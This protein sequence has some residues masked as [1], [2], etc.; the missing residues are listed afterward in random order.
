MLVTLTLP[1]VHGHAMLYY[2]QLRK[3]KTT[4]T[5]KKKRK[6][7]LST[8]GDDSCSEAIQRM[9]INGF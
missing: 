8:S 1:T 7:H 6:W 4:K 5:K 3:R 9:K 2:Q